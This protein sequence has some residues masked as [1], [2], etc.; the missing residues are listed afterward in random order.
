MPVTTRT[1]AKSALL[2]HIIKICKYADDTIMVEFM[3]QEGWDTLED[4]VMIPLDEV[5]DF[6]LLN[7]D[8]SFKGKPLTHHLR[9]FKAFILYY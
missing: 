3:K 4:I 1:T 2:N 5:N 7:K 8:G 9:K 6:K